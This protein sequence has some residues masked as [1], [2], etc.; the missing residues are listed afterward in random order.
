M[1]AKEILTNICRDN[2]HLLDEPEVKEIEVLLEKLL[3][4]IPSQQQFDTIDLRMF[5][6]MSK[7]D[8]TEDCLH[9]LGDKAQIQY[10]NNG[11]I[12]YR[13]KYDNYENRHVIPSVTGKYLVCRKDGKIHFEKYNGT[14][15]AYNDNSIIY[16]QEIPKV[17]KQ[18]T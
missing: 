11:W 5:L 13:M 8:R 16:W 3:N 6:R 18:D 4:T 1:T 7:H 10:H 15:F 14:G 17:P 2:T 9:Y 12:T